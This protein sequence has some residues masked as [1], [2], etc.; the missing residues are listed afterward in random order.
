V[1]A[2]ITNTNKYMSTLSDYFKKQVSPMNEMF[3]R[4]SPTAHTT[5][6]FSSR[7][8]SDVPV[9]NP[10]PVAPP[11]APAKV[12]TGGASAPVVNSG[13]KIDPASWNANGGLYSPDE[14][15]NN[16]AN[17]LKGTTNKNYDVPQY[18]QDNFTEN[19]PTEQDLTDR[20]TKLNNTRN[21][22]ATG[23][24]DPYGVVHN[25]NFAFTPEEIGAIE[26]A[27]AGI[28]DPALTHAIGKLEAKQ[29][30]E[31]AQQK[32][33]QDRADEVFK[34]DENIRQWN[35]TTGTRA[36]TK[37]T[38]TKEEEIAAEAEYIQWLQDPENSNATDI[39]KAQALRTF[40]LDPADKK[41]DLSLF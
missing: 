33:E 6:M 8:S 23:T 34:T 28:Y 40:N 3:N 15:A 24:T 29:K 11:V 31:Q 26:K 35:A 10:T 20:A 36:S 18:T 5:P 1:E 37:T 7:L 38:L 2:I 9:V 30:Y 25:K 32:A 22:I 14:Y 21:D 12:F 4:N 19:N 13:P 16:M 41:Y 39:E 17:N 27:Y